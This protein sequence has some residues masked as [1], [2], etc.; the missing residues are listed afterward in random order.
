MDV[1][2]T[3]CEILVRLPFVFLLSIITLVTDS[4]ESMLA[5]FVKE[6]LPSS[7]KPPV[8]PSLIY[9]IYSASENQVICR[10]LC[11]WKQT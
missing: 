2:L 6:V 3:E 1:L 4:W 8:D 10:L 11:H 9:L 7:R 5:K